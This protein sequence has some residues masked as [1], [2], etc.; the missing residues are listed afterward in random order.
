MRLSHPILEG[1]KILYDSA[2]VMDQHNLSSRH[3]NEPKLYDQTVELLEKNFLRKTVNP[4]VT[5]NSG[6]STLNTQHGNVY[7]KKK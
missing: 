7:F 6:C 4:A 1:Q 2:G 5:V 3:E